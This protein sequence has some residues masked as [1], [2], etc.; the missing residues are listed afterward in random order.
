MVKMTEEDY[1]RKIKLQ[2]GVGD[3]SRMLRVGAPISFKK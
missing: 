2:P 3:V 1:N